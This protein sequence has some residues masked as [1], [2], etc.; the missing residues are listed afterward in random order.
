MIKL[1]R[2]ND[3]K[4]LVGTKL[5]WIEW[6][7]FYGVSQTYDEPAIGRSLI[8]DPHYFSYTWLTTTVLEFQETPTGFTFQ[9]ENSNYILEILN[10]KENGK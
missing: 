10:E 9:T 3:G 6:D 7:E 8:L 2:E 4:V 5:K 1:T